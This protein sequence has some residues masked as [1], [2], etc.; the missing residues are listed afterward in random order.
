MKFGVMSDTHGNLE[1]MQRAADRMVEEYGVDAIVHL[2]DDYADAMKMN[3]HGKKLFAVPGIFE[4]AWDDKNIPHRLIKEFGGIVF[5]MSHTP[6]KVEN[7]RIGDINPSR[8]RSRFGVDVLLHGHS[9]RSGIN[10]S[11]DGLIVVNPGHLKSGSDKGA[12][13]SFAVIEAEKPN[14][15]VR[16]LDLDDDKAIDVQGFVLSSN[17]ELDDEKTEE[18][19]HSSE[20]L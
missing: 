20:E 9:H 14:V 11:E 12:S 13:P 19:S 2:G 16:I 17:K 3:L 15:V 4:A 6:K 10:R 1:Y 7:D 18:M 5:L 8:A